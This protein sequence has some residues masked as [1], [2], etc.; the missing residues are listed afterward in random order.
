MTPSNITEVRSFFGMASFY[1]RFIRNFSSIA[2]PISD[3]LKKGSFKWTCE[4]NKVFK[5]F[6]FTRSSSAQPVSLP[7]FSKVFQVEYDASIMGVGD[8]LSQEGHPV[9]FHSE[10]L[11]MGRRNW[12][13]YE[14]E[15]Y[16]VVRT[17]KTWES[18]LIQNEFIV[19]T[20]HMALKL[21]ASKQLKKH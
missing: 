7:D 5:I 20:D 10:K 14:Q 2:A 6:F 19:Q 1:R 9:A 21:E 8:V 3:C 11:S 15:L 13:T 12:T 18:Y 16:A 17:C 4:A